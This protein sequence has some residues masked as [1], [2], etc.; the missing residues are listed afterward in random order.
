MGIRINEKGET[1]RPPIKI[2]ISGATGSG[3][4]LLASYIAYMLDSAGVSD[5]RVVDRDMVDVTDCRRKAETLD[6]HPEV[7]GEVTIATV[8]IAPASTEVIKR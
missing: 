2:T 7:I 8:T 1:K 4:T 6:A 3:K 5:I